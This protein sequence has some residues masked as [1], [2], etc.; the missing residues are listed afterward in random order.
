MKKIAF[1]GTHGTRKTTYSLGLA[2]HLRTNRINAGF[3]YEVA[4][5]CPLPIN[6][7]RTPS[8]QR[9]ILHTQIAEELAFERQYVDALI[10]DRSALDNYAYFVEKFERNYALDEIVKDHVRTYDTLIKVPILPGKIDA[11]DIRSTDKIFQRRIDS[12]VDELLEEFEVPYILFE[13]SDQINSY[14]LK[15]LSP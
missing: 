8:A 7:E 3:L 1:I 6:E 11:D 5:Q 9:W 4:R 14:V 12:V 2:A 10:C 13:N 15:Y